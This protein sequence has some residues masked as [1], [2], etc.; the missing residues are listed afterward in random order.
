MV[1][2][3][4]LAFL[5]TGLNDAVQV[6]GAAVVTTEGF[7]DDDATA[8]GIGQQSGRGQGLAAAAVKLWRNRKIK[9]AITPGGPQTIDGL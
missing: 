5:G 8:I 2:A 1:D 3:E 9:G 7:F 4:N 6:L